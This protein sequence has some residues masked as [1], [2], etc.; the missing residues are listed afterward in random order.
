[1]YWCACI[2]LFGGGAVTAVTVL[3]DTAAWEAPAGLGDV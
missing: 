3:P 1:M 2:E